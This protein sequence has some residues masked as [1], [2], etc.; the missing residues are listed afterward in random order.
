MGDDH[1]GMSE[2]RRMP[3][4]NGKDQLHKIFCCTHSSILGAFRKCSVPL[5][6]SLDLHDERNSR[7]LQYGRF[8]SKLEVDKLTLQLI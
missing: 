6:T 7:I 8:L 4:R 1:C 5:S 2:S 3:H